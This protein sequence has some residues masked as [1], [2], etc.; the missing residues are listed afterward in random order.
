VGRGV[1]GGMGNFWDSTGNVNEEIPNKKY[2]KKE[3][4]KQNGCILF[5]IY[6]C[7]FKK[8]TQKSNTMI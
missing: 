8:E 6:W 1:G 2:K 3:I 4:S 5:K 7:I